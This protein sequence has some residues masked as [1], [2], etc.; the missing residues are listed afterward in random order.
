VIAEIVFEPQK[1]LIPMI[2][3]WLGCLGLFFWIQVKKDYEGAGFVFSYIVLLS[4][5]HLFG[6]IIHAVPEFAM[7][8]S[9]YV[10][11][12][13]RESLWGLGAFCAGALVPAFRR[14]AL[15]RTGASRMEIRLG[16]REILFL[17]AAGALFVGLD[18]VLGAIP[19]VG[20][21]VRSGK[22]LLQVGI[23][24][25]TW[26]AI[27]TGKKSQLF[28]WLL[29]LGCYPVI[30]LLGSGF[31]SYATMTLVISFSFLMIFYRPRW[32]V[33]ALALPATYL[34]ISFFVAYM[35][36]RDKIREK[37]WKGAALEQRLEKVDG[38]FKKFEWFDIRNEEHL[39]PIDGR[40]NQNVFL[41]KTVYRIEAG[42][43][44]PLQGQTLWWGVTSMIPRILWP[45]KP[46]TAGSMGIMRYLIG[47]QLAEGT[48]FGLGQVL[49]GYANFRRTGVIGFLFLL[50]WLVAEL[51]LRCGQ[52]LRRGDWRTF[53]LYFLV[54]VPLICPE[55]SSIELFSGTAAAAMLA[56]GLRMTL[57]RDP[58][59]GGAAPQIG[60][61]DAGGTPMAERPKRFVYGES[62]LRGKD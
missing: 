27:V 49:E 8:D 43:L 31:L 12:G 26:R 15:E 52:A 22:T 25:G 3:I 41:G 37:V 61:R 34:V 42:S 18:R 30:G 47:E 53:S 58:G 9:T 51:D 32:H 19:S 35:R 55:W 20:A 44:L 56:W 45:D 16:K 46:M 23:L 14:A 10:A 36:E 40:L 21:A 4:L 5:I 17:I 33:I 28:A 48:S 29:C 13:F 38:I 24:L 39:S 54:T 2:G 50:G 60:S 57:L 7:A 59:K 62:R 1:Q 6:A 11:L